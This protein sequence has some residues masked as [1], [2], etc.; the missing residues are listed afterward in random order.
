MKQEIKRRN[1]GM[2]EKS[3]DRFNKKKM[4]EKSNSYEINLPIRKKRRVFATAITN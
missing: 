1:C 3:L 4:P 2:K